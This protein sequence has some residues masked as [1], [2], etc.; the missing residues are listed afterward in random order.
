MEDLPLEIMEEI[1]SHLTFPEIVNLCASGKIWEKVC[2]DEVFWKGLLRRDFQ[3]DLVAGYPTYKSYYLAL[4]EFSRKKILLTLTIFDFGVFP[5]EDTYDKWL[6]R[7]DLLLEDDDF[8][9]G[10]PPL[11]YK[12]DKE[13]EV[14]LLFSLVEKK[15]STMEQFTTFAK[16]WIESATRLHSDDPAFMEASYLVL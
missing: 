5:L 14:I 7:V 1:A 4:E 15:L 13:F 10:V 16:R 3:T 12:Q 8:T 2:C 11:R 9:V 6:E